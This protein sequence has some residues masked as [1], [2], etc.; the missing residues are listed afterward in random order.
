MQFRYFPY[1]PP[2][3]IQKNLNYSNNCQECLQFNSDQ[4]SRFKKIL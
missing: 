2:G 3:A 4:I 1:F